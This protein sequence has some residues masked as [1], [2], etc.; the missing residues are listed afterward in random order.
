MGGLAGRRQADNQFQIPLH[1][2]SD[3]SLFLLPDITSWLSNKL[4]A[5]NKDARVGSMKMLDLKRKAISHWAVFFVHRYISSHL[6][7]TAKKRI[8][9]S[10]T[11]WCFK[12]TKKLRIL[13]VPLSPSYEESNCTFPAVSWV[14]NCPGFN[15]LLLI[16]WQIGTWGPICRGWIWGAQTARG[17][18]CLEPVKKGQNINKYVKWPLKTF[19]WPKKVHIV[20]SPIFLSLGGGWGGIH[21]KKWLGNLVSSNRNC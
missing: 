12:C 2:S 10:F 4:T 17:P 5:N 3:C 19:Q 15:L 6:Q 21:I 20:C 13:N 18:I 16:G 7:L 8:F 11:R 1:C 14:S 9:S